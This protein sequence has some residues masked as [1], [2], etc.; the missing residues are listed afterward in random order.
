MSA[1]AT[2]KLNAAR[3]GI[4]LCFM[5]D[6]SYG[7]EVDRSASVG[8]VTLSCRTFILMN[9]LL[10]GCAGS[11]STRLVAKTGSGFNTAESQFGANR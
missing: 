9:F 3:L 8:R 2:R 1:T 11:S 6:S 10:F 4:D 5:I 7:F